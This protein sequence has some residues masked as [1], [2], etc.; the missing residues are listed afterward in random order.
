VY[1]FLNCTSDNLLSRRGMGMDLYQHPEPIQE[2]SA[3]QEPTAAAMWQLNDNLDQ[4]SAFRQ[5]HWASSENPAWS[6]FHPESSQSRVAKTSK[7][8]R[9]MGYGKKQQ[10]RNSK[11]CMQRVKYKE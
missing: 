6:L 2:A 3:I 9:S 8:Q 1:V 7:G 11:R 5:L 4:T 10:W